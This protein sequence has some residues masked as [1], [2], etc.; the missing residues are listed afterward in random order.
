MDDRKG[1]LTLW[2][3]YIKVLWK[4]PEQF[5]KNQFK[6][7][8][9]YSIKILLF[10]C[11]NA[12]FSKGLRYLQLLHSTKITPSL[13]FYFPSFLLDKFVY[14][15]TQSKSFLRLKCFITYYHIALKLLIML[16][17]VILLLVSY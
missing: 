15:Y 16:S 7:I 13:T 9:T 10:Y 11:Q 8:K 14:E 4:V 5:K 17:F 1:G 2:L 6:E 3:L 12:S